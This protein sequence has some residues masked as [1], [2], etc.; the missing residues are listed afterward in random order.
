VV[1]RGPTQASPRPPASSTRPWPGAIGRPR[2]DRREER[3][4]A[5]PARR[6]PFRALSLRPFPGAKWPPAARP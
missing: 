6:G 3:R 4:R 5:R 1:R 2:E